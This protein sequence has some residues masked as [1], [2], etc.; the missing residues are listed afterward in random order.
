MLSILHKH[1]IHCGCETEIRLFTP[2]HSSSQWFTQL[3]D[4]FFPFHCFPW[5]YVPSV[6]VLEQ[7]VT[8]RQQLSKYYLFSWASLPLALKSVNIQ[9]QPSLKRSLFTTP[10]EPATWPAD[11]LFKLNLCLLS[12]SSI[13][14][15]GLP[16]CSPKCPICSS[17]AVVLTGTLQMHLASLPHLWYPFS[18][19]FPLKSCSPP[20]FIS[21]FALAKFLW[22]LQHLQSLLPQT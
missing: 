18:L 17:Q 6:P 9:C 20:K 13:I 10:C 3:I 19:G 12:T 16:V 7:A 14:W 2:F 1:S 8:T 15:S 21:G 4:F 5:S 22:H 11:V